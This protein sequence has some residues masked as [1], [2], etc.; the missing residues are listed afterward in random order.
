M[1]LPLALIGYT[2]SNS[3]YFNATLVPLA[4]KRANYKLHKTTFR[5]T[6]IETCVDSIRNVLP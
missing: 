4:N 2:G 3:L 5:L 1:G 6:R